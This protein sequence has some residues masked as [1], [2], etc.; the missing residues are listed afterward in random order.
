MVESTTTDR[1]PIP[2]A[3]ARGQAEALA[4]TIAPFCERVV[5]AGS[6]RR[7]K[8][9]VKDVELA[10]VPKWERR[11]VTRGLFTESEPVNLLHEW[12]KGAE[13]GGMVRWTRSQA[14]RTQAQ[15]PKPDGRYWSG[16]LAS[17]L[18][19]DLFL[20]DERNFGL[21]LALRTG[22]ASWS[23]ALVT[24][25]AAMGLP[26]EG[27]SLTRDGKPVA[28]PDEE[29]LFRRLRLKW[30]EPKDR[31]EFDARRIATPGGRRG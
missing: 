30:R 18:F 15:P 26:S 6:V 2:L 12:A 24:R 1:T 21:I 10:A 19:L 8:A 17:G 22:P 16:V 20:A 4:A 14:G 13:A 31:T 28:T 11:Q 3:E 7:G 25:A 9:L 5:V 23:Q 29:T 27:G